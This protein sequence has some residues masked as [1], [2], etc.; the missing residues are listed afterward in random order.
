MNSKITRVLLVGLALIMLIGT[1]SAGA[2]TPY[3]TYTYDVNGLMQRSPDAYTPLKVIDSATLLASLQPDG[4][5][6]NNAKLLYAGTGAFTGLNMPKDFFVDELE[7]VYIANTSNNQIVVTDEEFNIRLIISTF[8]N[9]FG[10]PDSLNAPNGVFVTDEEIFVADT[11]NKRIVI[12]DKLGNFVDIVPEPA[13]EVLPENHVYSPVAVSV[14]QAGRIYV[15]SATSTFG[16]ISLNRDGS[17]NG[18]IG[19]Q[20]VAVD[21]FQYF[22]R[23]FQT[24]EQIAASETNVATE[25]NNICIDADGF[26]YATTDSIED[27][28]VASAIIAK[29]KSG[30][31]APVKKLNPNGTDVMN[32]NGFWPPSGEIDM[33]TTSNN[34]IGGG[35]STVVDV[36]I[37]PNN[38]WSIIDNKRSRVFTYDSNGN[39]LFAF[40]DK[41]TQ[42][43]NVQ[44]LV[45]VDY[46]G[47]NMILLDRASNTL[48]VYKRTGYGD[49]LAAAIQNTE[50][51]QFDKAVNYYVSILQRN[52]NYDAAYVGIA[53]SLYRDGE[54]EQAMKYYKYAYNTEDY[55][56]AYQAYRKEW[57]EKWILLIP[58]VLIAVIVGVSYFF[59]YANKV[60]KAGQKMK[61][62]RTFGE[63]ILYGFHIIFH[64]FDGFWDLKHEKRGSVRGAIFWLV[65]TCLTF[66]YQAMGQSYLQN[67]QGGTMS[68]FMAITSILA[69]VILWVIANWCITTLF[70]GEGSF[71]DVFVATCYSLVPLPMLIIPSVLISNVMTATELQIVGLIEG[72]AFGWLF[73]LV[74]F[75]MMVTHDYSLG[76][77]F[78]TTIVSIIGV[79]FIIFIAGLFSALIVKVFSFFYQIYIELSY[80]WS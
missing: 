79:A 67:P 30:D 3:T 57:M 21:M 47:T 66:V 77:N 80:R 48:T 28:L 56:E 29:D 45:A 40:G 27:G 33:G 61:D 26:I 52:N 60:N 72:F 50:D 10:V 25:F 37:G 31:Y 38:T 13:S 6:S 62:K 24:A 4:G 12:F 49:L 44:N 19:A 22:L 69:P 2:I 53:D 58:L 34:S 42:L 51:K 68:Y 36:A 73:L 35:P 71:K 9:K 41:G 1:I 39:L 43:G 8:T 65:I 20:K 63:E 78:I 17:F 18:F 23:L 54:Y 16:I 11:G 64:P 75:G 74:F 76:K 55:S 59:K 7:H 70:E 14:D 15:V 46:Q 32:R 5:A